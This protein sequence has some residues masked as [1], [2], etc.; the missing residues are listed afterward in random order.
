MVSYT[1]GAFSLLRNIEV[2][3]TLQDMGTIGGVSTLLCA[4]F[5]IPAGF[6][7]DRRHPV[8]VGLY[9]MALG[10]LLTPLQALFL[11][12][13]SHAHVLLLFIFTQGI[14]LPMGIV[15]QASEIPFM[16]R[17]LPRSR[18]GQFCSANALVR[19]GVV[20]VSSMSIGV[21]MD[22]LKV[23]FEKTLG[24]PGNYYY[25][26][27]FLWPLVFVSIALYFRF[28]LYRMWLKLG[29]DDNYLPPM[30]EEEERKYK[31]DMA[32]MNSNN[33]EKSTEEVT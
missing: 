9:A 16:M 21:M 27:I 2:G 24:I 18:F 32:A 30:Y 11:I 28:K 19:S 13:M 10:L 6:Y 5:L 8:R 3:L 1:L 25:R 15:F 7:V 31:E 23:Y 33:G 17:V 4:I 29:G 20:I 14:Q 26:L 12:R 22:L